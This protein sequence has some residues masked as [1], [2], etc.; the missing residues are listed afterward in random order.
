MLIIKLISITIISYLLI[1]LIM[2]FAAKLKFLDVPND[3]SHHCNIIPRGAG[4]GF[5][6]ATLLGVFVYEY[7]IFIENLY[8]FVSISMVLSVGILDDRDEV[9]ARLKFIV[10]FVATFLMWLYGTT[11]DTFG[12]WFGYEI[13]LYPLFALLFTM[14]ALAGFTNALNLIDGIDGLSSSIS[15]VIVGFFGYIGYEYSN[16][17]MITLSLFTIAGVVGFMFLNWHPA[18]VFMGDSGSLSLGFIISILAVL[19]LDYIHP[20]VILYLAAIP[21]LDTLI[22]M[23]RRIRRG[24]SP[25]SPDK[26]HLHHILVKFFEGRVKKTVFF[27]VLLQILFSS[28]GYML[29]DIINYNQNS[30]APLVAAV[31]FVLMFVLFYMIF[32]GIKKKQ[33]M[34]EKRRSV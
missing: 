12:V 22:V 31:G 28:I 10:I 19:S 17:L 33:K 8:I 5:I 15:V 3:R 27:L 4:A 34:M 14:F 29:I 11:I 26:T 9:S 16:S 18:K 6:V 1:K 23:I 21:I 24:K 25:F 32:T 20:I 13:S 30:I 2:M 7:N